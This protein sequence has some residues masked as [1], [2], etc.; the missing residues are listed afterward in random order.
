MPPHAAEITVPLELILTAVTT[1][2]AA[3]TSAA[4]SA[5]TASTSAATASAALWI[6]ATP[7]QTGLKLLVDRA[8]VFTMP[9]LSTVIAFSIEFLATVISERGLRRHLVSSICDAHLMAN[10]VSHLKVL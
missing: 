1:A 2:S 5:T 6:P 9:K 10:F 7:L 8:I 4:T 3:A